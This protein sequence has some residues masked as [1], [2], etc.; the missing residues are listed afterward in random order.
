MPSRARGAFVAAAA[1]TAAVIAGCGSSSNSS[2]SAPGTV[3]GNLGTATGYLPAGSSASYIFEFADWSRIEQQLGIKASDLNSSKGATALVNAMNRMG[4]PP[5]GN[6]AYDLNPA[7]P[8]RLWGGRDVTWDAL[9]AG[10]RSLP[11]TMTGLDPS[12]DMAS[13]GQHLAQCGFTSK[14][15]NGVTVYSGTTADVVKCQGPLGAN[16]PFA[17]QYA[18]DTAHHTVLTSGSPAVIAAALHASSANTTNKLL[19]QVLAPLNGDQ[20]VAVGLGPAFCRQLSNPALFAGHDAKP[21]TI[22]RAQRAY[23]PAKP[24]TALG[25]GL[26]FAPQSATG[27]LVFT[28]ASAGDAKADVKAREQR[29]QSGTS[30][31][32]QKPYGS[33]ARVVS[34]EAN[35]NTV[36]LT[37]AQPQG[38]PIQL[39]N[40]FNADDLGFA[41]CG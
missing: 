41:R 2:S 17:T 39:G 11:L 38:K 28:Y 12:F 19:S 33:L 25:F 10:T 32:T 21:A 31:I 37:I 36:V 23:P 5:A 15:V 14:K 27:H 7:S 29:L 34:G 24:Y 30:L 16:V 6:T 13:V 20:A 9:T 3:G 18:L 35:G 22:R 40:M 8:K 1:V 26:K 4:N